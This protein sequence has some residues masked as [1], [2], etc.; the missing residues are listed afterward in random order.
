MAVLALAVPATADE[1]FRLQPG[2][3]VAG[4]FTG[5]PDDVQYYSFKITE[6]NTAVHFT[7][8]NTTPSCN[9][10]D[11]D[12]GC[13]VWGTLINDEQNQLGGEGSSAG[14]AE[15]D[16]GGTDVIDWVIAYP[17]TYWLAMDSGGSFPS[18][19]VRLDPPVLTAPAVLTLTA[20]SARHGRAVLATLQT[21]RP[22][23]SVAAKL[24]MVRHRHAVAIGRA[25][26]RSVQTG[27]TTF[28]LAVNAKGRRALKR[29]RRHRLHVR[30][31]VN[32]FPAV[33]ASVALRRSVTLH[34]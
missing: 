29:A 30:L 2:V 18:Y 23:A 8:T 32:V 33:G 16:A 1:I 13:A 15:V 25:T 14:T 26:L 6:P 7:V 31:A 27:T 34:H 12:I 22:L 4:T 20:R 19:R 5:S 11:G 17:G 9:S 10:R 21:G 28:S 3:D 24:T